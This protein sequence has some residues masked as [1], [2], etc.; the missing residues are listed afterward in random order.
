MSGID[1]IFECA[2]VCVC[3]RKPQTIWKIAQSL[4]STHPYFPCQV[5]ITIDQAHADAYTPCSRSKFDFKSKT[6]LSVFFFAM[7]Q[8]QRG[9]LRPVL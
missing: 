7:N 6:V 9:L 4:I 2:S 3:A 1:T 5:D 8:N